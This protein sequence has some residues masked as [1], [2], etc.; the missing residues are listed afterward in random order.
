MSPAEAAIAHQFNDLDQQ[1]D[2]STLGMWIF[3]VTEVMF[4]GGLFAGYSVYRAMPGHRVAGS[5]K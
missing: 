4:F 3:L 1:H 2:A 5:V